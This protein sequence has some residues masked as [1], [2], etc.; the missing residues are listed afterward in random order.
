MALPLQLFIYDHIMETDTQT[1]VQ[2]VVWI[3]L[4]LQSPKSLANYNTIS[5]PLYLQCLGHSYTFLDSHCT[6]CF[7][8]N[9]D[10]CFLFPS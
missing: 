5:D 1:E 10:F 7:Y 2:T 6:D 4:I 3:I 8:Y 9:I